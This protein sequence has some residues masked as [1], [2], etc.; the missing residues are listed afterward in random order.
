V[1]NEALARAYFAGRDP[2][3]RRLALSHESLRFVARDRPPV[4][5]FAS[6]FR[7]VVGVVADVRPALDTQARPT[8]YVPLAQ[9]PER[10][11]TVILRAS[12]RPPPSVTSCVE[13]FV[14]S[15]LRSRSP[16]SGPS[17]RS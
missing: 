11:M 12:E 3:G 7:V 13:P 17:T 2:L 8:V 16:R 10:Q 9:R 15:I 6:A 1:I 14:R 5:D 4:V